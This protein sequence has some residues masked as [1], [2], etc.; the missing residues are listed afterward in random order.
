[1]YQD[2]REPV[3][4]LTVI[5]DGVMLDHRANVFLLELTWNG[6]TLPYTYHAD[7]AVLSMYCPKGEV[8]FCMDATDQLRVRGS[9]VGL[10]LRLRAEL[11]FGGTDGALGVYPT[12][13]G[14]WEADMGYS[15][16]LLLVPLKGAM[17]VTAPWDREAG[18]YGKV[19]FDFLPDAGSGAFEAVLHEHMDYRIREKE[20]DA[21]DV[22]AEQSRRDFAEY[23]ARCF[24]PVPEEWRELFQYVAYVCW[25]HR[26]GI[27]GLYREPLVMMQQVWAGYCMSWQQSYNA[28]PMLNDPREGL[29]MIKAFFSYQLPDGHLPMSVNYYTL[30]EGGFQPAFQALAFDWLVSTCGEDFLT[31]EDCEYLYPRFKAWLDFWTANRSAGYGDDRV[32]IYGAH[33]SG[34]DDLSLYRKGF[35]LQTPD[36]WSYMIFM[37]DDLSLLARRLGKKKEAA[38]YASRGKRL[39]GQLLSELWDGEQFFGLLTYTGER[40]YCKSLAMFQC[41]C[42][43]NKRIPEEIADKLAKEVMKPEYLTDIGLVTESLLSPLCHFGYNFVL[44]R[45]ITPCNMLTAMGLWRCGHRD[46]ARIICEHVCRNILENGPI[47][48]FAPYPYEIS[49]GEAIDTYQNPTASDGWPWTSWAASSVLVMLQVFMGGGDTRKNQP[50][51]RIGAEGGV[52]PRRTAQAGENTKWRGKH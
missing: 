13:E 43:G 20:Y 12:P 44:G 29:R 16:K 49:T 2:F 22:V 47:L 21:F 51:D 24:R 37:L 10:R 40:V 31:R 39:L 42:L 52:K 14:C 5:K 33:E 28:L 27:A 30:G 46:E 38:E 41:L 4:G 17:M 18:K 19:I 9:G 36:L 8:S 15:G 48:G 23:C 32:H 3:L 35:P 7:E 45:V 11:P 25:S 50:E 1:M 26:T 34:W 6:N